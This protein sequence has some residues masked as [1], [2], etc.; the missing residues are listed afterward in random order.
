MGLTTVQHELRSTLQQLQPDIVLLTETRKKIDA[1][2][3]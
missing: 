3:A 1:L 2:T